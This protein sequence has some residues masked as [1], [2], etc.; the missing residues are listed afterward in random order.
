MAD[1]T[2][3]IATREPRTL[4]RREPLEGSRFRL[5]DRFADEMDRV[6]SDFGLGRGW[7]TP[8]LGSSA[9]RFPWRSA[10]SEVHAWAP[11]VDVYERNN[12]LVIHADLP[13]LSKDDVKVDV[14][15]DGIIIQGERKREHEE[16]R[17]GVYR[18]ERSH[19]SFYRLIPLPEGAMSDQAKATFKDGV[20]E[21]TMPVPPEQVR[22]GR[23]LEITEGT[24]A[25]K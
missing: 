2:T 10:G 23:R 12:E 5:L 8:R 18:A 16:E 3:N 7:S 21:I 14:T 13:G 9:F 11:D 20:L 19:G 24:A 17:E 15:E 4:A 1:K 25:K 22:R 6:F